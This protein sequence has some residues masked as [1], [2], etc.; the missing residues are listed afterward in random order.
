MRFK[1]VHTVDNCRDWMFLCHRHIGDSYWSSPT[2]LTCY[3][4]PLFSN[5]L[6]H[7]KRVQKLGKFAMVRD[8]FSQ[9]K[10][11]I[12][13]AMVIVRAIPSEIICLHFNMRHWERSVVLGS[14]DKEWLGI[15]DDNDANRKNNNTLIIVRK[16]LSWYVFYKNFHRI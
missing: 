14:C 9:S 13:L 16:K 12:Q 8:L 15:W 1:F 3:C 10:H 7:I 4:R 5:Q 2:S 6:Y 11:A